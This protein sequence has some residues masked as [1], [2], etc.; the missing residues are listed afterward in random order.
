MTG[1]DIPSDPYGESEDIF[2]ANGK[3]QCYNQW[4]IQCVSSGAWSVTVATGTWVGPENAGATGV[5]DN[6]E[7]SG[8]GS[9]GTVFVTFSD[10]H[11]S[12]ACFDITVM[13]SSGVVG[14]TGRGSLS[15]DAQ[16]FSLEL[17]VA[18]TPSAPG[19]TTGDT[20]AD[21]PLGSQTVTLNGAPFAGDAVQI[22]R[23]Q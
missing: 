22:Y 10:V 18:G 12:A 7:V 14:N 3:T 19:T 2:E 9:L 15:A 17:Y 20:C 6:S 21:G 5:C 4:T 1:A 23:L 8:G 13:N 16:T 11:A